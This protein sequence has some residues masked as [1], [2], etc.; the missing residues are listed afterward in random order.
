MF[1][2]MAG[3]TLMIPKANDSQAAHAIKGKT[4]E[5]RKSP[6]QSGWVRPWMRMSH[7]GTGLPARKISA[8]GIPTRTRRRPISAPIPWM[9]CFTPT[10]L[11]ELTYTN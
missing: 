8:A 1:R 9:N 10:S 7:P 4:C 11:L 3:M 5:V 2:T 6:V